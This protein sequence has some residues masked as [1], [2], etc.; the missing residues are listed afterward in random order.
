MPSKDII[1]E[2]RKKFLT[3]PIDGFEWDID[4]ARGWFEG[5]KAAPSN[6]IE[7]TLGV[8]GYDLV[9]FLLK[10]LEGKGG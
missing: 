1:E 5:L 2:Q 6:V 9:R 10:E 4:Y 8:V 3:E 7:K